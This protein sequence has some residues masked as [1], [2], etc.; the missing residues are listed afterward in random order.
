[1][2]SAWGAGRR[3]SAGGPG[4]LGF[5]ILRARIKKLVEKPGHVG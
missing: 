2:A 5:R 4:R 1:M 3:P